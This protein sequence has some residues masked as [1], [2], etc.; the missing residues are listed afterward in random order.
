MKA[1]V[2]AAGLGSRLKEL[3]QDQPKCTLK[4]GTRSM[5]ERQFDAFE[6]VGIKDVALVTGYQ[7]EKLRHFQG[8]RFYHN[9]DFRNNNI[10]FSLMYA[11]EEFDDDLVICY[12]D[13]VYR[14]EVLSGLLKNPS[15]LVVV[16][17]RSWRDSYVGR[18]DHPVD[19]AEKVVVRDGRVTKIGKHLSESEADGEFIGMM[20]LSKTAAKLFRDTARE[21]AQ[22]FTGRPFQAAKNVKNAY[23][24]DLLQELID[25]GHKITPH[26]IS[27]GWK[28]I[29][30]QEDYLSAQKLFVGEL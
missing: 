26:W 7:A 25:R 23:I 9:D 14:R 12:S 6:S 28:E 1:I 30:T 21:V 5:I 4:I 15:D 18:N 24:T 29:D 2:I 20:K 16:S 3:T 22:K 11:Q 10:L 17:D 13:I 8:I 27:G 19:Q